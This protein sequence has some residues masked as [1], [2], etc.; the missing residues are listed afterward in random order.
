MRQTSI[1]FGDNEPQVRSGFR[2]I[3]Y[4]GSKLRG[5]DAIVSTL[6]KFAA[7]DA[8]AVDLFSGSGTV[9]KFLSLKR[10][11]T[12]IDIQEY[13][14]VLCHTLLSP[15]KNPSM[16]GDLPD[17]VL[18]SSDYRQLV[19]AVEPLISY[20]KSALSAAL[21]GGAGKVCDVIEHGSIV[22]EERGYGFGAPTPIQAAKSQVA[23]NLS[24][25]NSSSVVTRH[26]GGL[27]FSYQQSVFLDAVLNV[28]NTMKALD[29]EFVLSCVMSTASDIV[30]T[31]GKQFAQPIKPRDKRGQI[32]Q[33]LISKIVKDRAIDVVSTFNGW[34]EKYLQLQHSDFDHQVIRSDYIEGLS[35]IEGKVGAVYADPPYTRDHYSRFYHVLETICIGDDPVI[36]TIKING[37]R[38]LSRGV[39]REDRHQSPFCIRSQAPHAFEEL[40]KAVADLRAPLILS[41]SPYS[42]TEQSHPRVVTIEQLLEIGGRYY[43]NSEVTGIDSFNHG[44]LNR[45]DLNFSKPK[46]SEQL[47]VFSNASPQR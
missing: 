15:P 3:H 31:V 34:V 30:N 44:K 37:E 2:P 45:S 18:K 47:L 5:L 36:S 38:K 12:A 19:H 41:Y 23:A 6:S 7:D 20:E 1:A 39:Y 35:R 22:E 26:F 24:K 10:P 8:R 13:S 14:R 32:K 29:K 4:L 9:T 17:I 42:E 28:M 25:L 40:F 16:L 11:V 27:Y 33:S 46:N 43:K 21:T